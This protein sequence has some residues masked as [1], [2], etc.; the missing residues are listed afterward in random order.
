MDELQKKTIQAIVNI[1]ETGRVS[2]DYGAVTVLK[3]DQGHLTYGRSQTTLASGYLF[4]LI[5]AYCERADAQFSDELRPFLPDLSKRNV[6]LDTNMKFKEILREAGSDP[7]MKAEQDRFFDDHFFNPSCRTAQAKGILSGLGQAV[8]YDSNVQG[9]FSK[10]TP[11]VGTSIG[12][13]GTTERD[14]IAKYIAARKSWL[15]KLKAPLPATTYRMD[16]FAKLVNDGAWDLPLNLTVHGVTISAENLQESA[17]PVRAAAV[18]PS[19]PP[20]GPIMHLTSPYMRGPDVRQLQEALSTNGFPNGRDGVYGPF[21]ETLVKKFQ[22]SRELRPDGVVGP[23]TRIA[24][25][26]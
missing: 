21:T 6:E 3:G 22:A 20:A 7:A 26:L 24:L 10:V 1:F 25:G 13:G 14:W 12:T 11:L 17:P 15:S 16:A 23:A 9:G 19:D 4:L 5:K 8:V 2:G 18:D